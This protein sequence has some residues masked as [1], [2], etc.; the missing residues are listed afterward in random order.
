MT[1]WLNLIFL[2]WHSCPLF[3]HVSYR[4]LKKICIY[5]RNCEKILHTTLCQCLLNF[6]CFFSIL[7]LWHLFF[8]FYFLMVFHFHISLFLHLT[9]SFLAT[10]IPIASFFCFLCVS[11]NKKLMDQTIGQQNK[12]ILKSGYQVVILIMNYNLLVV[13]GVICPFFVF[14]IGGIMNLTQQL[15]KTRILIHNHLH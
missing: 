8:S 14:L 4:I 3:L 11:L 15:L 6:K 9:F 10:P 12:Q 13:S 1:E 7:V 5:I 2:N